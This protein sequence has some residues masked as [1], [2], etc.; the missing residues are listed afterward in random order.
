[1]KLFTGILLSSWERTFKRK[2]NHIDSSPLLMVN[3][4]DI[5]G[6]H[7]WVS[8]FL[9][10]PTRYL[11]LCQS[12]QVEN[13][14]KKSSKVLTFHQK[15]IWGRASQNSAL[16][17]ISYVHL[18]QGTSVNSLERYPLVPTLHLYTKRRIRRNR[19]ST[20]LGPKQIGTC[21][22]LFSLVHFGALN[23]ERLTCSVFCSVRRCHHW[24]LENILTFQVWSPSYT[25]AWQ[26]L[27]GL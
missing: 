11:I 26:R 20:V 21:L 25:A 8:G 13:G 15:L 10:F 17:D 3:L 12:I 6:L 27:T 22:S 1:M 9:V 2:V 16:S 7:S 5:G 23:S 19:K 4:W 14:P 24:I 18:P